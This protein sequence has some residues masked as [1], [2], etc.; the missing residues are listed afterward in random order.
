LKSLNEKVAF[1]KQRSHR[2]EELSDAVFAIVMT[3]L[4]LD[5]RIP[6]IEIKTEG[7]VW[8]SLVNAVPQILT[9]IL[10]FSIVGQFWSVFINQFNHIHTSDRNETV[11]AIFCLLPVSLLPFSTSFLSE[12]LWSRVAI[13]FYIFNIFI[14]V[15][16]FTLHWMYAYHSGL[17]K[18][19]GNQEHIINKAIM[20]RA[21]III[22][23]YAL[24]GCLC[25]FSR[26]LAFGS[27]I[28][29]NVIII[30][31]S[32]IESLLWSLTTRYRTSF[33]N[34]Q[35]PTPASADVVR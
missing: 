31:S 20:R 10:S 24:V 35:S 18:V 21:R 9:F 30:F 33:K 22:T 27:T 14:I 12:H 28:L 17:V 26:T 1:R 8:R 25:F 15:V 11:I 6:L 13:G 7:A 32:L 4:V 19:E 16:M 29:L 3:L 2:I 23:A 34:S 5:I